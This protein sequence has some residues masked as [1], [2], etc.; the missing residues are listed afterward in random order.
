MIDSIHGRL[1]LFRIVFFSCR[2]CFDALGFDEYIEAHSDGLQ[3]L[4]YNVS[5]AYNSHLD[6]IEDPVSLRR[7]R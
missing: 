5:K 4:R 6:W 3:I 2:R 1:K 7:R